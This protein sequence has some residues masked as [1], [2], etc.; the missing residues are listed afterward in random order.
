MLVV[1]SKSLCRCKHP[2]KQSYHG[3]P[4]FENIAWYL[5]LMCLLCLRVMVRDVLIDR[6]QVM[7]SVYLV[8]GHGSDVFLPLSSDQ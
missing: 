5:R 2:I 3:T 1:Q 4:F 8:T 7:S 6:K